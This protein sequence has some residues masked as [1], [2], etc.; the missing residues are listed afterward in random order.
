MG[1]V[2]VQTQLLQKQ[3]VD[4]ILYNT[5]GQIVYTQNI[6]EQAGTI[7]QEIDLSLLANGVYLLKVNEGAQY[8]TQK[9]V[10]QN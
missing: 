9:I 4:F 6:R 1:N 7:N 2:M 3:N 8:F 10:K 5:M